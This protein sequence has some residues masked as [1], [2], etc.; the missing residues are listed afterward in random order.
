MRQILVY[1]HV[2]IEE[3][4]VVIRGQLYP[5]VFRILTVDAAEHPDIYRFRRT[6]LVH[7]VIWFN[8]LDHEFHLLVENNLA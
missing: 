6:Q 5:K 2:S 3:K 8:E 7:L 4:D 1:L